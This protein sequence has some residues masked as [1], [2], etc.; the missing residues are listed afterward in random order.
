[1]IRFTEDMKIGVPHIDEQHKSLVE[2]A[3]KAADVCQS[4]P[5]KEEMKGYLDFL[6][7]YV[8]RHF[9]DEEQLQ[10]ESRY[11]RYRLHKEIH[12]EF[13]R[14]FVSMCEEFEKYGVSDEFSVMLTSRVSN[15]IIT[16]IKK[17]DVAFGEY[18]T[19][20]KLDRIKNNS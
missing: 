1:M 11:P 8:T 20:A 10:V 19:K 2:F 6:G 3:N 9:K 7:T 16:H 15:W 17:E 18:Y 13:V 14:T 5:T 4:D 12:S